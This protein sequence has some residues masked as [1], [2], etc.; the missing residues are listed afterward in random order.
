MDCFGPI[1]GC[2]IFWGWDQWCFNFFVDIW[3]KK[4]VY[5]REW[6]GHII[7]KQYL[8]HKEGLGLRIL[9]EVRPFSF[10]SNMVTHV[11]SLLEQRALL[12]SKVLNEA[13]AG[14]R[15]QWNEHGEG[16]FKMMLPFTRRWMTMGASSFSS[17]TSWYKVQSQRKF[18]NSS[19]LAHQTDDP[20]VVMGGMTHQTI[21]SFFWYFS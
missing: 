18:S 15:S 14:G 16:I 8:R 5:R 4:W 6:Q 13:M 20:M 3:Y 1:R 12:S 17:Q 2:Q 9:S 19:S 11:Q 21:S 7:L 10:S